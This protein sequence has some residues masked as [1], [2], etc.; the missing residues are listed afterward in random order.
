MKKKTANYKRPFKLIG[1]FGL[2]LLATGCSIQS[3]QQ[4]VSVDLN[5]RWLLL[6]ITNFD[7]SPQA[8]ERAERILASHLRINGVSQLEEYPTVD[9]AGQFPILDD[10]QR[11]KKAAQWAQQQ[12]ARYWITGSISEWRY[13]N[14]LDGEPAVGITLRLIDADSKAVLWTATGAKTGWGQQSVA[15]VAN[16]LIQELTKNL[17]SE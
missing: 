17:L 16:G 3:A 6:P 9:D 10:S 8:G 5:D 2:L 14:G 12:T 4:S 7:Q 15:H 11:Y 1:L 13:K